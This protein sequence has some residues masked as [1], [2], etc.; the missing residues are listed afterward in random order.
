MGLGILE[1]VE[2]EKPLGGWETGLDRREERTEREKSVLAENAPGDEDFEL[3]MIPPMTDDASRWR[4]L[5]VQ[6][7]RQYWQEEQKKGD[8]EVEISGTVFHVYHSG[9]SHRVFSAVFSTPIGN[10]GPIPS[11]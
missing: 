5:R 11:F 4:R 2:R 9:V 10:P 7:I 6:N 8:E 1:A 3:G